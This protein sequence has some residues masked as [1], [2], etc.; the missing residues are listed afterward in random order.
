MWFIIILGVKKFDIFDIWCYEFF[1]KD[2]GDV[3]YG[4]FFERGFDGL[5]YIILYVGVEFLIINDI[6]KNGK[7]YSFFYGVGVDD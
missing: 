1:F 7:F 4:K 2:F 6:E 5:D 3:K